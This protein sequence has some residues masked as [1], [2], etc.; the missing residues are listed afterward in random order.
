MRLLIAGG[1][2]FLGSALVRA[3]IR[4]T[5]HEIINL[6]ALTYAVQP[7]ALAAV[8]GSARY[9]FIHG[10]IVD[11][12]LLADIF[13]A[14]RPHAVLHLAAESHVDRAISGPAPFVATNVNGTFA[15]LEAARDYWQRLSGPARSGFRF[16]H[17]STDEVYG[18]LEAPTVADEQHAYAPASPY[19]ASKAGADHLVNA[20]HVTYG[21]PTLVTH[22]VNSYGPFQ[23]P[24]KLVPCMIEA[25]L[26][27]RTLPVYGDGGQVRDWLHVDDHAAAIRCVLA[28]G[29][30]GRRYNI[31]GGAPRTN[32]S[33]VRALCAAVDEAMPAAAPSAARIRHVADR[34]GHDRRYA[35]DATRLRC[36]L[37]WEPRIPLD[38]GLV[39]TV[40]WHVGNRAR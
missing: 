34:P 13:A 39:D 37:G 33:L 27:G 15:L 26:D 17:V 36:T 24:E 5:D 14:H 9:T 23:H 1:A 25:A 12:A 31:A 20:W 11:G 16:L 3:L 18:S 30:P 38:R 2:G 35:V 6:D 10:D 8:D 40:A 21:L 28:A 22:G 19:A 4:E 29:Q 7:A 32:L